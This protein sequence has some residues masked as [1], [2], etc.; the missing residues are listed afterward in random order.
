MPSQ[1]KSETERILS[2]TVPDP[3]LTTVRRGIER[4]LVQIEHRMDCSGG[5]GT[6]H[7]C[8]R[9]IASK[10]LRAALSSEAAGGEEEGAVSEEALC[11]QFAAGLQA[12]RL[13]A[14]AL[15][16]GTPNNQERSGMFGE[17]AIL[18][19]RGTAEVA[20]DRILASLAGRV[21]PWA[22]VEEMEVHHATPEIQNLA[23]LIARA[24]LEAG[25]NGD[26]MAALV[27]RACMVLDTQESGDAEAEVG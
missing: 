8:P 21:G 25:A 27:R 7:D 2:E 6:E 14:D 24:A 23:S 20:A 11:P 10:A 5:L 12:K 22:I 1:H 9:C 16:A 17:G 18:T 3:K 13:I 15:L 19:N 4:A 26:E